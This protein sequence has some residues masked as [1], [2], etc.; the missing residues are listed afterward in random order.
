MTE[1]HGTSEALIQ[2]IIEITKKEFSEYNNP[3]TYDEARLFSYAQR[4][5]AFIRQ[6]IDVENPRMAGA[7]YITKKDHNV[8]RLQT[9]LDEVQAE[10]KRYRAA[11]EEEV[12]KGLQEMKKRALD[13]GWLG[14]AKALEKSIRD[15][16]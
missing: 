6:A 9:R 2:I 13:W 3:D 14:V 10:N 15:Y 16:E 5:E 4:V 1:E 12:R 8:A 11:I 7:I